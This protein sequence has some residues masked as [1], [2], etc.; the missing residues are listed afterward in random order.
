MSTSAKKLTERQQVGLDN[1]AYEKAAVV[2]AVLYGVLLLVLW[3]YKTLL[4]FWKM[5][6]PAVATIS[7]F[8]LA[9]APSTFLGKFSV[10]LL[11]IVS[12]LRVILGAL[13]CH[14]KSSELRTAIVRRTTGEQEC[15]SKFTFMY[16]LI[17]SI[18]FIAL[19]RSYVFGS[20]FVLLLPAL[21]LL[22]ASAILYFDKHFD[23]EFND[24]DKDKWVRLNDWMFLGAALVWFSVAFV[25]ILGPF[26][27]HAYQSVDQPLFATFEVVWSD[28]AVGTREHPV[29]HV[30]GQLSLVI[31]VVI[32]FLHAGLFL[33]EIKYYKLSLRESLGTTNQVLFKGVTLTHAV[34][35]A[36]QLIFAGPALLLLLM[37]LTLTGAWLFGIGKGEGVG[38]TMAAITCIAALV[39]APLLASI[40]L[41][42]ETLL[43]RRKVF[44]FIRGMLVLNILI[45]ALLLTSFSWAV[46]NW[47]ATIQLVWLG[48]GPAVVA[49]WN[50]YRM[51]NR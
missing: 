31:F 43:K 51:R 25:S 42:I 38:P 39:I 3:F 47:W 14:S 2:Y 41:P 12:N 49:G 29:M 18:A 50:L 9:G 19:V 5:P 13:L 44:W 4:E 17:K 1:E 28:V 11:L 45:A 40:L 36:L 10:V 21:L 15:L 20:E 35:V 34:Q 22:E 6:D 23:H 7:N 33:K 37:S 46:S 27:S 16:V 8:M 26:F 30:L 32:S 48:A 24:F